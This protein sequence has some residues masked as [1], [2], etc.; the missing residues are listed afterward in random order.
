MSTH[1]RL[2]CDA[3]QAVS[4]GAGACLVRADWTGIPGGQ[5]PS[6]GTATGC[7]KERTLAKRLHVRHDDRT[8]AKL[9]RM[10]T[11]EVLHTKG[12]KHGRTMALRVLGF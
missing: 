8:V 5:R 7:K 6:K 4:V 10:R 11:H 3:V 12:R 1:G 9:R 2:A